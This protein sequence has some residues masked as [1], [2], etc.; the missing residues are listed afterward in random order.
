[1]GLHRW[2]VIR[3]EREAVAGDIVFPSQQVKVVFDVS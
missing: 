2:Q 1:M 3:V